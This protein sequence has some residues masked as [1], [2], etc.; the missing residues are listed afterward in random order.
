MSSSS[1]LWPH[2]A[3]G[4]VSLTF[5]DGAESQLKRAIPLMNK[6]GLRGTF[7]LCPKGDDYA[8]RLAVWKDVLAAGHEIGNHSLNHTCSRNF[9]P[10]RG[11][12][13]LETM[14]LADI[15]K[16]VVDAER[17][18]REV[19]GPVAARSFCYPCYQT[20]VGEGLTRQS[21]VPVIAKH[22]VAGRAAGEYAFF[23]SPYNA[24]LHHL[25]SV[26]TERMPSV[27]MVGLAELAARRG[28]WIIFVF[29][30][31]GPA[32]LGTS[33]F[34]FLGLIDHLADN[35]DRF[36]VAPVAEVALHLMKLRQAT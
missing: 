19:L 11:A 32:R 10:Q 21:Y 36:W 15:E 7:Y 20:D 35:R 13:G 26:P 14:S 18:L 9:N 6:R 29:H 1:S 25:T 33:E 4:A 2:G 27:E 31:I 5:D 16:D 22:F 17:R 28:H 30:D 34:D 12:R 8:A 24:D 23:N 3:R